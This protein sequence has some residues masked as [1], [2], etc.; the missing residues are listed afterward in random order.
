MYARFS[1]TSSEICDE[2]I[3]SLISASQSN[4]DEDDNWWIAVERTASQ[5]ELMHL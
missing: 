2:L 4:I 5:A 3:I 1:L